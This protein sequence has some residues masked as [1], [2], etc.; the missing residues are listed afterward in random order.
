MA[1]VVADVR[2][3]G[4][5][6]PPEIEIYLP[7]GIYPEAAITLLTKNRLYWLL[8]LVF[9]LAGILSSLSVLLLK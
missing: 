2:Y 6:A 1:G 8:G 4:L 7:D 3:A 9:G 5:D